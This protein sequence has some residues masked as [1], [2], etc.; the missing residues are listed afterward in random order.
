MTTH[1]P[2]HDEFMP[3]WPLELDVPQ[4]LRTVFEKFLWLGEKLA[5]P[6]R[7]GEGPNKFNLSRA[8][9]ATTTYNSSEG[10]R[11]R[12]PATVRCP[13]C[14]NEIYQHNARDDIDCPRCIAEFEFGEFGDLELLNMK[15]PVCRDQ[16]IHGQ[17]HPE[18]F[19]FPEWATCDSC[20]YH[21]EFRHSY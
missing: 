8:D 1:A 10:W 6:L 5:K 13:R 4:H 21:W 16:M 20:R 17:R 12:P 15:C 3:V 14:E 7:R 11:N 19:D 18:R 9:T 2:I